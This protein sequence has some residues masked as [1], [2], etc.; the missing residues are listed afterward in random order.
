MPN[1]VARVRDS[2]GKSRTEKIVAESLVQARTNLRD[3]GF[4]IQELKQSQG[5]QPDVAFKNFQNSLV[6]VSVKD[7]AVFSR[8]FAVLMNA[9]V[10]IVRSLGVLSE[11]CSNTKLKQALVDISTDVQS[12]MNL[13]EAM[14]KHPDCFDGLYVSMIQAG[15]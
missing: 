6:K 12:G 2:Q 7:K 13:S 1:F 14:R 10:A 8:Q 3:Q 5:F 9:G 11:Q 15:E 4:V